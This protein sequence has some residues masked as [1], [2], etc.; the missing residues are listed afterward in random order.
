MINNIITD[1]SK[2]S[3]NVSISRQN[4]DIQLNDRD[5]IGLE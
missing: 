4:E 5:K 1:V 2:E 3:F